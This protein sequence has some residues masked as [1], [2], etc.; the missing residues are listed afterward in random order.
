MKGISQDADTWLALIPKD[1]QT[2]RRTAENI[3][4]PLYRY[5]EREVS[6]CAELIADIRR[7]LR[8]VLAIYQ[9]YGSID[10]DCL[11]IEPLAIQVLGADHHIF[12]ASPQFPGYS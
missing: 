6:L 3:K 9:V 12:L 8:D 2:L 11:E 1:I 10:H 5:F 7:D 4:D